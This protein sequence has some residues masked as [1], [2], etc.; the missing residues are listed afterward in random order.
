[1]A[2]LS[3]L[4]LRLPPILHSPS[5]SRSQFFILTN[6]TTPFNTSLTLRPAALCFS[7]N[8]PHSSSPSAVASK[9]TRKKKKIVDEE[10]DED[11]F[12]ALFTQLEEDLKNDELFGDGDGG[13][14]MSDEELAKLEKELAE[15]LE[16]DELF[17]T[18]ESSSREE[19]GDF[20]DDEG[21]YEVEDD[22][23]DEEQDTPVKL[24]NWQLRR[25]AYAL[26]DGRRKTRIKNLAADLF[27]DRA[28]VL[29]LLRDPPPNLVMLSATLPDKPVSTILEP[30]EKVETVLLETKTQTVKP[31][32]KVNI[33][34]H[35]KQRDWYAKK[36]LKKVQV[37]TLEQ[38]YARTKRPTNAMISSIV[39]VLNL[40]WKIVVKW[41]EDRRA[42]DGV[43]ERRLPY[44]GSVDT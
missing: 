9:K 17:G 4:R 24:K 6:P 14:D 41:F 28:V 16:D 32:V 22:N 35:V 1:M 10:I 30:V 5:S 37:R 3:A 34:V 36:R 20:A 11:A 8:I 29:K 19:D 27:L 21:G 7:T 2:S 44:Q 31:E 38:I 33:P 15:A 26:K 39:H 40:P 12:E 25:L 18:L 23:E 42:E 43:P 13:D